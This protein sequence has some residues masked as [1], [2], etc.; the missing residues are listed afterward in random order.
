MS[1]PGPGGDGKGV[2]GMGKRWR[3]LLLPAVLLLLLSGCLFRPPDELYRRPEKSAGYDQLATAIRGV[4]SSLEAEFGV[5]TEDAVIVSG[6]NTAAIQL[7]DLDGDGVRESALTFIRVPGVEKSLKIYIFQQVGENY[8]VTGLV[9]GAGAAIY[10]IDYADLNGMGSKE[11]VV[12]WQVSAGVYQLGAYTLDELELPASSTPAMAN[13]F[14]D[15]STLL[16]TELLLTSCSGASEGTNSY[17]SGCRLLDIDQDTRIEIAVVRIESAGAGSTVELYGWQDGAFTSLSSASLSAGVVTLNRMRSNYLSGDY[18]PPALYVTC[19]MADG[20][21]TIDVLAYR[22]DR[23][24]NLSLDETGV[25]ENHLTGYADVSLSDVNSDSVLELPSLRPLPPSGET[26]A[27]N[28]WLIDWSQYNEKGQC[29]KVMTTYHNAADSWYLEIPDSWNEQITISRNDSLSGQRQV[30][31]SYWQGKDEQP[32]PF[33][34]IY[35]LT[36]SNRSIRAEE[37]GRFILREE[38]E[39]IYAAKFYDC[40]WDCGWGQSELLERFKTIQPS[41]YND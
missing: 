10:S 35:R 30:I 40:A 34:S 17:S 26:G 22:E 9:E 16:A 24:V 23:L 13:Q 38:G 21:K 3:R 33:L 8:Q 29:V 5:S 6:D 41:W 12:N 18:F 1:S 31:F 28:F 14:Q 7:Q 2:D 32:V 27:V 15:R 36:G 39:V 37:D 25:S 19:T 20:S 11:L 4:R